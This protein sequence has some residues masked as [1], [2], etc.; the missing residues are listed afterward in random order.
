[1]DESDFYLCR[2]YKVALE[3]LAGGDKTK[4]KA[5]KFTVV[6]GIRQATG[7][8]KDGYEVGTINGDCAHH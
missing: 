2:D 4:R 5:L 8:R 7:K 1:M 6:D 3:K